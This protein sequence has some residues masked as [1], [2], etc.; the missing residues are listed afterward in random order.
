MT[1]PEHILIVDDDAPFVRIYREIFE[2]ERLLVV[3]AH[4]PAEAIRTLE[5]RTSPQW[6]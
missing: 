4:S 3:T 1:A 6:S 2:S 5:G